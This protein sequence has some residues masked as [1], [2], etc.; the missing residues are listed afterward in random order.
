MGAPEKATEVLEEAEQAVAAGDNADENQKR[1]AEEE[2]KKIRKKKEEAES[3]AEKDQPAECI[4]IL[5]SPAA[6]IQ[7]FQF[8][9]IIQQDLPLCN[10]SDL[11]HCC[12]Q[13]IVI[14]H[15][16][17]TVRSGCPGWFRGQ[18]RRRQGCRLR[19]R[20]GCRFLFWFR[21]ILFFRFTLCLLLLLPNLFQF[22]LSLPFVASYRAAIEIDPKCTDAYLGLAD[23]YL[24]M[25][26]PE[27]AFLFPF[28]YFSTCHL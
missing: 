10:T 25:G 17:I 4:H 16:N 26:A 3:K 28:S 5:Y 7:N 12:F 2:L 23:V 6:Q 27:K 19:R 9:N 20:R 21:C 22:L 8:K 14:P 13:I 1:K 15:Y 24:A 18:L 11:T